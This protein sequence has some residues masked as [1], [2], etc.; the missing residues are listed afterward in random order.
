MRRLLLALSILCSAIITFSQNWHPTL[1]GKTKF[2]IHPPG[3]F[4]DSTLH[5]F[6][7][8]FSGV[9]GLDSLFTFNRINRYFFLNENA[10]NCNGVTTG[11]L[12]QFSFDRENVAGDGMIVKPNGEFWFT[13]PLSDSIIL[14]TQTPNGIRWPFR[15]GTL[16]SAWIESRDV[17]SFSE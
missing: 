10:V 13:G 11:S 4:G 7:T 16:D 12:L 8:T 1:P 15:S 5:G 3:V 2:F 9:N 14:K 17:K 6:R